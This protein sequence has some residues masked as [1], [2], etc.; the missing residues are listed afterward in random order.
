MAGTEA[1]N[2]V[3]RRPLTDGISGTWYGLEDS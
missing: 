2:A 3:R 1:A